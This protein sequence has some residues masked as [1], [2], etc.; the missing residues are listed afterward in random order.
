MSGESL[1]PTVCP[2]RPEPAPGHHTPRGLTGTKRHLQ[3]S[4]LALAGYAVAAALVLRS[5]AGLRQAFG[6]VF[7]ATPR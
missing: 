5:I 7:A 2:S 4:A 3:R 1:E 6:K